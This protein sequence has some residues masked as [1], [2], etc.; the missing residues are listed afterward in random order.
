MQQSTEAIPG[1]IEQRRTK[2]VLS[3]NMANIAQLPT[4][5]EMRQ[6]CMEMVGANSEAI[7]WW[8]ITVFRFLK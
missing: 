3:F 8:D 7:K 6:I 1:K 5:K 4:L 2:T